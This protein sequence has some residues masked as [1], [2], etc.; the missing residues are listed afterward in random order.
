MWQNTCLSFSCKTCLPYN[1]IYFTNMS[2]TLVAFL[3]EVVLIYSMSYIYGLI[4]LS[5]Q[6]YCQYQQHA[7]AQFKLAQTGNE[8]VV[9][10]FWNANFL[11]VL[12]KG[13]QRQMY[14][15]R[16]QEKKCSGDLLDWTPPKPGFRKE[17]TK[18]NLHSSWFVC[19]F[20]R[21]ML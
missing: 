1:A 4:C 8:N 19:N 3:I 21:F 7:F 16:V 20:Y 17:L 15:V 2:L 9:L 18:L 10:I 13:F 12:G 5:R 11:S 6:N 14:S